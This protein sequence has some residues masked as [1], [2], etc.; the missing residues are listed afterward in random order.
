MNHLTEIVFQFHIGAIRSTLTYNDEHLPAGF[1]FHIGAIRSGTR[2]IEIL[3]SHLF[4]F[5]IGAIR[6]G[7]AVKLYAFFLTVSIPY[8]CN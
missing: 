8:W 6:S 2:Y 1:Q 7:L 3:K 4:Q 5:H